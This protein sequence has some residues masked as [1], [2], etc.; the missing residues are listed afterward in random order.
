MHGDATRLAQA[1]QNLLEQRRQVHARWRRDRAARAASSGGMRRH[2]G[3]R[4]RPRHRARGARAHLRAVRAGARRRAAS[5]ESGLGIGLSLARSLVELHGGTLSAHSEGLGQGSTFT[6]RLPLRRG[7]PARPAPRD[8][9]RGAARRSRCACWWSTTT[10]T[11]PTRWSHMLQL[12]GHEARAAYGAR[13]A[14]A[15]ARRSGRTSCCSTSTCPTAT[16]SR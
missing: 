1:L 2:H 4:Q 16:A 7:A 11:P 13:Q 5:R 9:G 15:D 12:L 3:R 14:L 6:I 8:A 10:A